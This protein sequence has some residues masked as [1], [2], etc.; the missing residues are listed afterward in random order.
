MNI[1]SYD[2]DELYEKAEKF[3]K[4]YIPEAE[5]RRGTKS[6]MRNKP[7]V[8][9]IFPAKGNAYIISKLE[10]MSCVRKLRGRNVFGTRIVHMEIIF[11]ETGKLN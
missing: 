3:I 2:W 11:D 6:F 10:S 5:V 9:V 7:R 1:D 4:Q 8:D